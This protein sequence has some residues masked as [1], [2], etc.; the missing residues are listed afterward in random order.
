MGGIYFERSIG[1]SESASID[2]IRLS[3]RKV[4]AI[5]DLKNLG[6]SATGS[7]TEWVGIAPDDSPLVARDISSYEIYALQWERGRIR[8]GLNLDVS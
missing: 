1:R 3:D 4:E 5:V 8:Q 2:R 6:R 7:V